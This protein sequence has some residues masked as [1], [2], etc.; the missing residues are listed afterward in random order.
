MI[1]FFFFGK[2]F[3]WEEVIERKEASNTNLLING[4]NVP[5]SLLFFQALKKDESMIVAAGPVIDLISIFPMSRPEGCS[6]PLPDRR[7]DREEEQQQQEQEVLPL[8]S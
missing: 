8:I 3:Y 4:T 2:L 7:K 5:S 6:L 1:S